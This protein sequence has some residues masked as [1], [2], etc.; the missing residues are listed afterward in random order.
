MWIVANLAIVFSCLIAAL[1]PVFALSYFLAPNM[2]LG[3][4]NVLAAAVPSFLGSGVGFELYNRAHGATP[5]CAAYMIVGAWMGAVLTVPA[6]TLVRCLI[7]VRRFAP[8]RGVRSSLLFL[9]G[10]C[11][12]LGLVQF[13]WSLDWSY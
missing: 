9:A 2:R 8:R 11:V 10:V 5:P 12:L 1:A 6:V 7:D 4:H 3:F 13:V